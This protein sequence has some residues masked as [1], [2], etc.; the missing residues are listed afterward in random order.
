MTGPERGKRITPD[1]VSVLQNFF[2]SVSTNPTAAQ[3]IKLLRK[4][5]SL[6]ENEDFNL[7]KLRDWFKRR[8]KAERAVFA[9]S[10]DAESHLRSLLKETPN[11]SKSLIVVWAKLLRTDFDLLHR[12]VLKWH[13]SHFPSPEPSSSPEPSTLPVLTLT[14]GKRPL[15]SATLKSTPI[16]RAPKPDLS[17][18]PQTSVE[19]ASLKI[20]LPSAKQAH[21]LALIQEIGHRL[22]DTF[23]VGKKAPPPLAVD[24]FTSL[25][26]PYMSKM[27][28]FLSKVEGGDFLKEGWE[29]SMVRR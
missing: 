20:T 2:D 5:Q 22:E 21:K 11:P 15:S 1:G 19:R 28:N 26:A 12:Y 10:P 9:L 23:V 29:P 18:Q 25:T 14:P 8:R 16:S 24:S 3:R 7:E 27:Q 6:P 17:A 13:G 4:V